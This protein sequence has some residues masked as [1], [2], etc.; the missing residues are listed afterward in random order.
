MKRGGILNSQLCKMIAEACH[1]DYI[2][3]TD[4]GCPRPVGIP[5]IDLAI[6]KGVP[7]IADILT[8]ID[9]EMIVEKI[10]Y[11]QELQTNNPCLHKKVTNIFRDADSEVVTHQELLKTHSPKIKCF[12]RT[13]EYSP[14]GNILL[15]VGSDPFLWFEDPTVVVPE[16][17]HK[18]L[19]QIR[20]SGKLDLFQNSKNFKRTDC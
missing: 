4:V 1:G 10:V 20:E 3:V 15:V 2:M 14:W 18:R 17:Y 12:V 9:S 13:G 5:C 11:A 7:T 16:F 19:K 6:V 8:L